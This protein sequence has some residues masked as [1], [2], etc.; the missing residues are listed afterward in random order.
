MSWQLGNQV[1]WKLRV[2][3]PSMSRL[4]S[5]TAIDVEEAPHLAKDHTYICINMYIYI[6][7]ICIGMY[8]YIYVILHIYIE[9]ER[10]RRDRREM[11]A[12]TAHWAFI[13]V[14][15]WEFLK[16]CQ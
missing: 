7:H 9:R 14:A 4:L 11:E 2:G 6:L 16:G 13:G 5:L 8:V 10:E 3:F 15:H 12:V 1:S